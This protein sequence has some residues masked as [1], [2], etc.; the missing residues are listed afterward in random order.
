M[1]DL[2]VWLAVSIGLST[3]GFM[4]SFLEGV[5]QRRRVLDSLPKETTGSILEG[6]KTPREKISG[7]TLIYTVF[8]LHSFALPLIV[9]MLIIAFRPLT[10]IQQRVAAGGLLAVG[11]SSMF[12]NLGRSLFYEESMS[13]LNEEEGGSPKYFGRYHLFMALLDTTAIYGMLYAVLGLVFSGVLDR[14]SEQITMAAA[15]FFFTGGV[16]L[17]ISA[18]GAVIMGFVFKRSKPVYENP[19][20]FGKKMVIT[21]T[22]H[23]I[24]MVGL[25]IAIFMMVFSGMM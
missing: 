12:A 21:V 9:A 8:S 23:L 16:I 18:V 11:M 3:I 7:K 19:D 10:S 25:T 15:D 1:M 20:Y 22:P 14:T 6:E 13:G 4:V 5:K 17:G 24:N 2:Y